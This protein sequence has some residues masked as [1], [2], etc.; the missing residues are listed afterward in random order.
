MHANFFSGHLLQCFVRL[1]VELGLLILIVFLRY[2]RQFEIYMY[3]SLKSVV[4]FSNL[5]LLLCWWWTP[6]FLA[7]GCALILK[8]LSFFRKL[9]CWR[10]TKWNRLNEGTTLSFW[11]CNPVHVRIEYSNEINIDINWMTFEWTVQHWLS[12][13]SLHIRSMWGTICDVQ[14]GLCTHSSNS[15][16]CVQIL[17]R[18]PLWNF[19][20]ES[21]PPPGTLSIFSVLTPEYPPPRAWISEI[22]C[23]D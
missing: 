17:Q 21:P 8:L 11:N 2:I 5:P 3:G 10:T 1:I 13:I 12:L 16:I 15:K 19:R 18:A 22:V 7:P 20:P 6:Y 9:F 23:G 4:W 14:A